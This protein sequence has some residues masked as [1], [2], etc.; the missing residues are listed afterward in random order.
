M[1]HCVFNLC[2]SILQPGFSFPR[3]GDSDIFTPLKLQMLRGSFYW[4]CCKRA[5]EVNAP[6]E[7]EATSCW[8]SNVLKPPPLHLA[9][10]SS[11]PSKKESPGDKER[12]NSETSARKYHWGQEYLSPPQPQYKDIFQPGVTGPY[13]KIRGDNGWVEVLEAANRGSVGLCTEMRIRGEG[14][15]ESRKCLGGQGIVVW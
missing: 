8:P 11:H 9:F 4:H 1:H 5:N 13:Q 3:N 10:S 14:E 2:P 7:G 15:K 12:S 6:R